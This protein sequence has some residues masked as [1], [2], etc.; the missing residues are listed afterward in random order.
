MLLLTVLTQAADVSSPVH[1]FPKDTC[2]FLRRCCRLRKHPVLERFAQVFDLTYT[3]FLDLQ[4]AEAQA[5][6]AQIEAHWK[7]CEQNNGHAKK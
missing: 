7:E 2:H 6:E 1:F 4:K 3:R 5:R